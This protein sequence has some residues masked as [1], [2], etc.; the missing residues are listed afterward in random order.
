MARA[1]FLNQFHWIQED[2]EADVLFALC[3]L[4]VFIV[5]LYIKIESF[6]RLKRTQPMVRLCI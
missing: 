4:C 5:Y 1:S 3:F 6:C 2:I